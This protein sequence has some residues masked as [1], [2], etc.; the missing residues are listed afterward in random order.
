MNEVFPTRIFEPTIFDLQNID[1]AKDRVSI[2]AFD[3][4]TGKI[5]SWVSINKKYYKKDR[6]DVLE[7]ACERLVDEV[8]SNI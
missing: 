1:F 2:M 3:D 6:V 8:I 5:I 7:K 4:E